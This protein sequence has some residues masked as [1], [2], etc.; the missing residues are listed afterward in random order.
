MSLQDDLQ[1]ECRIGRQ[2]LK[3]HDFYEG[4]RAG[5][6]RRIFSTDILLLTIIV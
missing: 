4:V 3:G 2:C 1:M 6:G 5:M